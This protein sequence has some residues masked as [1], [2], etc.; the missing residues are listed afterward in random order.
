MNPEWKTKESTKGKKTPKIEVGKHVWCAPVKGGKGLGEQDINYGEKRQ[1]EE[2][3]SKTM[4]TSEQGR[5]K[6]R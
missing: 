6:E 5:V 4:I 2:M 3:C 1:E